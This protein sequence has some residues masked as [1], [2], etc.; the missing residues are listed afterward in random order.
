MLVIVGAAGAVDGV[1]VF[2]I[3]VT[4][5]PTSFIAINFTEYNWPF[6]SS[7]TTMGLVVAAGLRMIQLV[8]LSN[9]YW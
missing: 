5:A 1:A 4:L 2:I 9:E 3:D 6:V 8:P 7:S